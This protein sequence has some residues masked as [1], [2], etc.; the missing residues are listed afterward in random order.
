MLKDQGVIEVPRSAYA[1][2]WPLEP[3]TVYLNHGSFGAC[4]REVLA[5]QARLRS[6]LEADPQGFYFEHLPALWSTA[7]SSLASFLNAD[8]S[9][10]TFQVNSTSGINAVLRSLDLR[11]DEE[12]LVPDHTYQAC[13]HAVDYACARSGAKVVSVHLPFTASADETIARVLAG[14]SPST[15]LAMVDTVC[16]PTAVR[17]PFEALTR[18][19]QDRGVDVLVDGS[20]GAGLLPLDL[21][22][23]DAAYVTGNCHK[24]L[25]TPKGSGFLHVRRDRRELIHPLAISHGYSDNILPVNRFREEFDWQGTQDPT[26]WLCIPFAIDYFE[27]V[28]EGGWKALMSRGYDLASYARRLLANT[29]DS[30]DLT[31]LDG[32][33][34]MV[35]LALPPIAEHAPRDVLAVDPLMDDLYKRFGIR[36]IVIPW[37]S[38]GVRYL[39]LSAA[40]YN[41][42]GDF[43]YLAQCL[44]ELGF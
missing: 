6:K 4:P 5:E 22:S 25:F 1:D 20:H 21:K 17:M 36:L 26:P 29:V 23:L 2:L 44:G 10:M 28:M 18:E 9:G 42:E 33:T 11:A 15:R 3:E 16:S 14:I 27:K 8:A 31:R 35:S 7:L 24:W 40:P 19:I 43:D 38:H 30:A 39:R 37:P 13:R 34:A 32:M 41:V 12:I